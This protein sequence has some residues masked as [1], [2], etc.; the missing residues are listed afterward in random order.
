MYPWS[1]LGYYDVPSPKRVG[2][3]SLRLCPPNDVEG[4]ALRGLH[5]AHPNEVALFTT[6]LAEAG[7]GDPRSHGP[8]DV[9]FERLLMGSGMAL[10]TLRV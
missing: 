3:K 1:P 10:T 6:C 9:R 8:L 2:P 5:Q 7:I 4:V